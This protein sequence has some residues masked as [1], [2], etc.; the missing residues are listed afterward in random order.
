MG[1]ILDC[2]AR[3]LKLTFE[4]DWPI[5][6]VVMPFRNQARS[7]LSIV[8]L[9]FGFNQVMLSQ[10]LLLDD[11]EAEDKEEDVPHSAGGQLTLTDRPV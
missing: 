3:H 7:S 6:F 10:G 1:L 11:G 8:S 2:S 9:V 5:I 4:F